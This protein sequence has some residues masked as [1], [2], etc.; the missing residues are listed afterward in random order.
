LSKN[1]KGILIFILIITLALAIGCNND[2][3]DDNVIITTP[4]VVAGFEHTVVLRSDGTVWAW[5]RNQ[6]AQLGNGGR[7]NLFTPVQAR[8]LDKVIAI[9]THK[10]HTLALRNDGTVWA[11]GWNGEGQLGSDVGCRLTP[12]QVPGLNNIIAIDAG[13]L[14]SI[15][16]R[17]DGTV[18]TWGRNSQGQL[19]DGS[20]Y[21]RTPP[22]QILS[23]NNIIAISGGHEHVLALRND[24]TVWAWG[25]NNQGQLGDGTYGDE[26]NRLTPVQVQDLNNV[27]A[28]AAGGY[29]SVALTQ[30]GTVWT[31]GHNNSGQLGIGT[32]GDENDRQ[33]V[34]VQV[35]NLNNIITIAGGH[36]HTIAL[37]ND[38]TGWAWGKNSEG[39]LGNSSTVDSYI[40]I[41]VT[42]LSNIT[43]VS[44]GEAHTVVLRR[45]GTVWTWG[46]NWDGQLGNTNS[47][48]ISSIP[49]QVQNLNNIITSI[50]T[51]YFT[52]LALCEENT[53]RGWGRNNHGQLGVGVTI[54]TRMPVQEMQ[55]MNDVIAIT[56][57]TGVISGYTIVLRSNRS[58]WSWGRNNEGQ[59]GVNDRRDRW[60]PE[61]VLFPE[62]AGEITAI[63]AGSEHSVA[64]CSNGIVW[65]W[66]LNSNGQ[67]G[68]NTTIRRLTPVRAQFPVE[69]TITA[70]TAGLNRT[71]ALCSN[72]N[73][74]SW[75]RNSHGQLGDGTTDDRHTPVQVKGLDGIIIKA[76]ETFHEH[77]VALAQDGTVWTWGRNWDGQLGDGTTDD[78]HTPVQVQLPGSIN[79]ITAIAA[80]GSH[81]IVLCNV[82]TVWSW[83]LNSRG[84]LGDSTTT[85]RR[86]TPVQ[87][88]FPHTVKAIAASSEHSVALRNDGSVWAWGSNNFGLLGSG[89]TN[90]RWSPVQVLGGATGSQFLNLL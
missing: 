23:L 19:G 10:I 78:R 54:D 88:Q 32:G 50:D 20:T 57:G 1:I 29:Y 47:P 17:N 13:M 90:Y 25:R 80:G 84:Q 15:A 66:G 41:Q 77:T 63:A 70:I 46:R 4:M 72:G 22:S 3:F 82:G 65:A 58:V 21:D 27:T 2:N 42:G 59:L 68:N 43:S 8:D 53:V 28:I 11:W 61:Q 83:G 55:R 33:I 81:T 40:P 36:E 7:H 18:W 87:V 75:G 16:L 37:C 5:G 35:P 48:L 56:A 6:E 34:P 49:V 12:V 69:I 76:I 89:A 73:V 30:D 86:Q 9:A 52:T 39:Q 67:V 85:W 74:W 45:D 31:W 24:G 79:A 64:L 38:N 62:Q 71:V 14:F 60:I 44:G 26:N 51:G